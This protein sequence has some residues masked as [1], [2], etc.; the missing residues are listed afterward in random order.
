M[1]LINPGGTTV[2]TAKLF[3]ALAGI[4]CSFAFLGREH[5]LRHQNLSISI[6]HTVLGPYYSQLFGALACAILAFAYFGVARWLQNPPNQS[7]GLVSFG[8]AFLALGVWL[9]SG[10]FITGA[11]S[12]NHRLIALLFA[13][14]LSFF[15]G[16]VLSTVNVAFAVF[17]RLG[18]GWR[19][20]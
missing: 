14:I 3:A 10:L 9:I 8:L 1:S 17:Q 11:S 13:A 7:I 15:V 19:D 20:K 18:A 4:I 5:V 16:L 6:G 2:L 12:P